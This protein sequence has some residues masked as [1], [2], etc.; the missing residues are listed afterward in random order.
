MSDSGSLVSRLQGATHTALHQ[1]NH[2][3]LRDALRSVKRCVHT[4]KLE[5][6]RE[7]IYAVLSLA[8]LFIDK[9]PS[10]E[11]ARL[12]DGIIFEGAQSEDTF[13]TLISALRLREVI[14]PEYAR[15]PCCIELLRCICGQLNPF[16]RGN[17]L[18]LYHEFL[19]LKHRVSTE[20]AP[21]SCFTVLSVVFCALI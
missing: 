10:S 19:G 1:N 21:L 20:P 4:L 14:Q 18:L 15:A 16:S 6:T 13:S 11:G 17:Y 3:P 2:A 9:F 7:V 12:L 8:P 5:D